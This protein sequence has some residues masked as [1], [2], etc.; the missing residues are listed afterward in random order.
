MGD[1]QEQKRLLCIVGSMDAGG[2]ET[3]LMKMYRAIDRSKYQMDFYVSTQNKAFYD[4]EILSM[5]G[6]IYNSI[7]KTKNPVKSFK[8]LRKTVKNGKYDYVMR[9]SQHSIST[10]ELI[11]AKCGG[12]KTLIFRSSNS[13]TGGGK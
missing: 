13:G 12:A 7:P 9:I 10:L 1:N 3:F 11:A 4:E 2:A 6:K 5:A 8:N